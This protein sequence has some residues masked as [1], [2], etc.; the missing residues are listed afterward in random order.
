MKL[1]LDLGG[2]KLEAIVLGDQGE[3]LWRE[4]TL[5]PLSPSHDDS[6]QAL[7][8]AYQATLDTIAQL[9]DTAEKHFPIL[10]NQPLG[11]GA[12]GSANSSGYMRNCNSVCLNGRLLRRDL[13]HTLNRDVVIANDANCF[14]LAE[15]KMGAGKEANSVFGVILGTGV[16]GGVVINQHLQQGINNVG[17]EWGHNIMPQSLW[18]LRHAEGGGEYECSRPCYCGKVNCIE[19]FLSGPG[20]SNSYKLVSGKVLP[21]ENIVDLFREGDEAAQAV[22][23]HYCRCLAESLAQVINILDPEV[24]VLGGGLSNIDELYEVVP[25]YWQSAVFSDEISTRLLKAR[26]GDSAGVFGAAWLV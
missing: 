25:Q 8:E 5:I 12:P 7:D 19:T 1:G 16:G 11:I 2:T 3:E 18:S 24:I 4:R 10:A 26:L 13:C 22:W 21:A 14:A 9:V 17:G 15:A 6:P 20:L 23:Q